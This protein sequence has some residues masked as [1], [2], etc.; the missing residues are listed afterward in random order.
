MVSKGESGEERCFLMAAMVSFLSVGSVVTAA[1]SNA[2]IGTF[3]S[4]DSLGG[5]GAILEVSWAQQNEDA[6]K[7]LLDGI[8]RVSNPSFCLH[9]RSNA[10]IGYT[11]RHR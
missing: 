9:V 4:N 11:V 1:S 8:A 7:S 5:K 3:Q 6:D 10:I 2:D